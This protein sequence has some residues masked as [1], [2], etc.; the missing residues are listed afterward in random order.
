MDTLIILL[1]GCYI[2]FESFTALNEAKR[3]SI[4]RL[5]HE[6]ANPY[7][8]K[9]VGLMAYSLLLLYHANHIHGWYAILPL[10]TMFFV[11]KRTLYRIKRYNKLA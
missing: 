3:V 6:C 5:F 11:T 1:L 4:L 8:V 10:P 7:T 9:Y 2:L